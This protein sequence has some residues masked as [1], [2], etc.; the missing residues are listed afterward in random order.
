MKCF[1]VGDIGYYVVQV[2][3]YGTEEDLWIDVSTA[4]RKKTVSAVNCAD[5]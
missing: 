5:V 2:F 4:L 3:F 1:Y